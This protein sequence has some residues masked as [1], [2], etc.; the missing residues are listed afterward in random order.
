MSRHR[1]QTYATTASDWPLDLTTA[2]ERLEARLKK[3]RRVWVP[4]MHEQCILWP[5]AVCG[6]GYGIMTLTTTDDGRKPGGRKRI[7]PIRVHVLVARLKLLG[8]GPVPKGRVVAH[9]CDVKLCCNPKHLEIAYPAEN[10]KDYLERG[11][12]L[13]QFHRWGIK[14][15][16]RTDVPGR[17]ELLVGRGELAEVVG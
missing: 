6:R 3:A 15:P 1:N 9:K 4:R 5:G 11:S 7:V 16:R 2:P 14:I 8:G 13:E 17:E 10:V 12:M